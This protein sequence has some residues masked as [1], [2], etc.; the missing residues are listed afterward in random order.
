MDSVYAQS[1]PSTKVLLLCKKGEWILVD[2]MLRYPGSEKLDLNT[3]DEV[4]F[5]PIDF[6]YKPVYI[7]IV[8]N[9]IPYS[10]CIRLKK[11]R[12]FAITDCLRGR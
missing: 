11:G 8:T 1:D 12:L 3:I 4:T 7:R 2:N 5:S 10:S 6:A 9:R